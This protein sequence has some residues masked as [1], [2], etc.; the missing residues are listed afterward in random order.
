VNVR[1][2]RGGRVTQTGKTSHRDHGGHR[3]G[4]D[5][6]ESSLVNVWDAGAGGNHAN[7]GKH[8]TEVTEFTE[9]D[10][11]WCESSSV[12]VWDAGAAFTRWGES[13]AQRSR[14]SQR[15]M[16]IGGKALW[17][18]PG[19]DF[20]PVHS[21]YVFCSSPALSFAPL[22]FSSGDRP[23][24]RMLTNRLSVSNQNGAP[25]EA[26]SAVRSHPTIALHQCR[27]K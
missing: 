27:V 8:R 2:F 25:I 13:I 22:G 3:G 18:T 15:G 20:H 16:R 17:W 9:G 21:R 26:A 5:W 11:D 23:A 14:R 19:C 7:G 24:E 12:N 10:G 4:W 6:C 1:G